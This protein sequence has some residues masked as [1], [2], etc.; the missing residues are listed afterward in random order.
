M[1]Q[2]FNIIFIIIFFLFSCQISEVEYEFS[3]SDPK[4][5]VN[6]LITA[7][8]TIKL[9]ITQT[10]S[11]NDSGLII[12]SDAKIEFF[13]NDTSKGIMEFN[14]DTYS[15][16]NFTACA[17]KTYKIDIETKH[18][19]RV[20]T[21]TEIPYKT[22]ITEANETKNVGLTTDGYYYSNINIQFNDTPN[23][24]NYYQV[25]IKIDSLKT[26]NFHDSVE[27][28]SYSTTIFSN[29][30]VITN[31]IGISNDDPFILRPDFVFFS[32]ELF[33]G[34]LCNLELNIIP[35]Y[36]N[37]QF[38]GEYNIVVIL[39]SISEDYYNFLQSYYQYFSEM[40]ELFNFQE[41]SNIYSNIN[42]GYGIFA[43]YN[44]QFDTIR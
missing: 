21:E 8:S 11:L 14:N 24:N 36:S 38:Y 28:I 31:E 27:Y 44:M 20:I 10:S 26:I 32:D 19:D 16:Y 34:E 7:D 42:N 39:N 9:E 12:I 15:L 43:G 18:F 4:I 23:K 40:P 3:N 35:N 5:V 33:N 30:P 17:G 25:F 22:D 37:T 2:K 13:E 29:D 1:T 6:S 41:P